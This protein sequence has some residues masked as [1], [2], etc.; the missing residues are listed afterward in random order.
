MHMLPIKRFHL[1]LDLL[2]YFQQTERHNLLLSLILFSAEPSSL[3]CAKDLRVRQLR[4]RNTELRSRAMGLGEGGDSHIKSSGMVIV[5][6]RGR[7]KDCGLTQGVQDKMPYLKSYCFVYHVPTPTADQIACR[8][9][10]NHLCSSPLGERGFGTKQ[11]TLWL[12][13]ARE[14]HFDLE[15]LDILKQLVQEF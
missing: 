7:I 4:L 13:K 1:L 3:I 6:L 12:G 10:G 5:Q 2:I 9:S 15:K 8:I 11:V 14:W